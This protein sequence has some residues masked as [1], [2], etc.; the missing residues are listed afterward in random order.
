[1]KY[2]VPTDEVRAT[3]VQR[4]KAMKL[5]LNRI[6]RRLGKNDA[7][8]HQFIHKKSPENLKIDVVFALAEILQL[9]PQ[10]L[11]KE[12]LSPPA[13]RP[14]DAPPLLPAGPAP[15]EIP[16]FLDTDEIDRGRLAAGDLAFVKEQQP[17]RIGDLVL[18]LCDKSITHIGNLLNMDQEFACVETESGQARLEKTGHRFLKITSAQFS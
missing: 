11:T 6:S 3:I 18:V 1:M 15:N 7:Y 16:V 9:P 4:A 5:G 14:R 2:P 10:S 8:M 13:K 17:P 12:R